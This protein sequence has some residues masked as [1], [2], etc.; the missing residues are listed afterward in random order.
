MS[1]SIKLISFF[2]CLKWWSYYPQFFLLFFRWIIIFAWRSIISCMILLRFHSMLRMKCTDWQMSSWKE[3]YLFARLACLL[4]LPAM[5]K[6]R[7]RWAYFILMSFVKELRDAYGNC[8]WV[9]HW[10]FPSALFSTF[11]SCFLCVSTHC[12][13]FLIVVHLHCRYRRRRRHRRIQQHTTSASSWLVCMCYV[14]VYFPF[15]FFN[16]LFLLFKS[17]FSISLT[18]SFFLFLVFIPLAFSLLPTDLASHFRSLCIIS[19]A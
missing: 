5:A 7:N 11:S 16:A 2:F 17:F 9:E 6:S 1:S 4:L 13:L 14:Y 8:V 3:S 12:L 18:H 19:V 10:V 15:F